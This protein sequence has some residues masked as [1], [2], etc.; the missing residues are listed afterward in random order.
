MQP[1]EDLQ[2][3]ICRLVLCTLANPLTWQQDRKQNEYDTSESAS[4][5]CLCRL[6]D[7][8]ATIIAIVTKKTILT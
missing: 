2:T 1:V 3:S 5:V 8:C 7:I 6:N 4:T